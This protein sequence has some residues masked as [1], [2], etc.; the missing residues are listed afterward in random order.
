MVLANWELLV[1]KLPL[2]WRDEQLSHEQL[3]H[4]VRTDSF[5]L[6]T[7]HWSGRPVPTNDKRLRLAGDW[8]R[9]LIARFTDVM[10]VVR[11]VK[12]HPDAEIAKCLR[13]GAVTCCVDPLNCFRENRF[14]IFIWIVLL[15]LLWFKMAKLNFKISRLCGG[16]LRWRR[17]NT[18][19]VRNKLHKKGK[20]LLQ[21]DYYR[22]TFRQTANVLKSFCLCQNSLKFVAF[23]WRGSDLMPEAIKQNLKKKSYV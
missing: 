8:Y 5:H 11:A 20:M 6:Q 12:T 14:E 18:P 3:S 1:A 15:S 22:L 9:C 23:Y 17:L 19:G 16:S 7:G 13:I 10:D 2:L 4:F 21:H